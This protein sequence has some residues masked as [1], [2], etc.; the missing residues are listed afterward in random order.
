VTSGTHLF[1]V[2]EVQIAPKG[3]S[4]GSHTM[5]KFRLVAVVGTVAAVLSMAACG[6]S[7]SGPKTGSSG[8]H[9]LTELD[10]TTSLLNVPTAAV[11]FGGGD[12][13]KVKIKTTAVTGGGTANQEFAGG[14]ADLLVAGVDSPIRIAQQGVTGMTILGSI[15]RTNVWVLVAKKGSSI[16]SLADLK[17]KTIG[18]SGPGAVSDLALRYELKKAGVDPASTKIVA[19]GAAPTQLAALEQGHADAVQL[20]SP[21]L[22]NA[23]KANKAQIVFDFRTEDYPALAVSARTKDVKANPA[24]FCAYANALK[25]SMTKVVGDKSY[26]MQI[27]TKL[28]GSTTTK[29]DMSTVLDDYI[30]NRYDPTLAFTHEQYDTAKALLVGSGAVKADGY[31]TYE[32]LTQRIP[33]CK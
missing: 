16:H 26:A 1:P 6:S 10:A 33:N 28:M 11:A 12:A 7:S 30:K 5:R 4:K 13:F 21:V 22:E 24:A 9:S 23:I 17:G 32:D 25:A 15:A 2:I 18:V 14:A 29:N 20:L 27:G 31:P 19:L 8:I 3:D